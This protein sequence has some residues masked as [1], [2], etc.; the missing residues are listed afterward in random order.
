MQNVVIPFRAGYDH[1][2]PI[3]FGS[4]LLQRSR[5]YFE[6]SI[7]GYIRVLQYI[8]ARAPFKFSEFGKSELC[9]AWCAFFG[10]TA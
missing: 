4:W 9:V 10:M 6:H 1:R 2:G 8:P 7:S 5:T 3:E